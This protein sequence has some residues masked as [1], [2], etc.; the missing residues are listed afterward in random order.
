MLIFINF[1]MFQFFT[2]ENFIYVFNF[3]FLF[4]YLFYLIMF[5]SYFWCGFMLLLLI[6]YVSFFLHCFENFNCLEIQ[7]L[8]MVYFTLNLIS[9]R[10][11][12]RLMEYLV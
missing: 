10:A 12:R 3:N 6:F 9:K 2:F 5:L 4:S 11:F 7:V 8:Q 1:L